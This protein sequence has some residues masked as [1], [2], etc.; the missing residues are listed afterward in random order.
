MLTSLV[1]GSL[2]NFGRLWAVGV[3]PSFPV[4]GPG[5]T[6]SRENIDLMCEN[7]I[8]GLVAG[9]RSGLIG[10]YI[11]VTLARGVVCFL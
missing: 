5:V 9:V 8:K 11:K 7:L 6:Y 10:L 2:N 3:V 4:P 1:L